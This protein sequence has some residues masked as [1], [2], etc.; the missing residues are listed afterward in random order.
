MKKFIFSILL[1]STLPASAQWWEDAGLPIQLANGVSQIYSDVTTNTMYCTGDLEHNMGTPEQAFHYCTYH[2]GS[3]TRSDPF[4]L[5]VLTAIIYHDTLIVGGAFNS[6]NGEPVPYI[7]Y[8]ANGQWHPYGSIDQSVHRLRIFDGELYATGSFEY[9]D[10]HLC[11]GVAKRVGG[12]WMN[13]GEVPSVSAPVQDIAKYNGELYI[14]GALH[15]Y[16]LGAH[17]IARYDGS[18]WSPVGNGILGGFAVGLRLA[19]YQG[20]L[21]MGGMI[22]IAAGNPG[23]AIMR[24]NGTEWHSVGT[25]LQGPNGGYAYLYTV[26]D[27]SVHNGLLYASGGFNYAGNVPAE[28][29]ATWDGERWC[30]LGGS[31]TS[32]GP[33]YSHGFYGDTLYVGCYNQAD[34]QPVNSLA[35]YIGTGPDTCSVIMGTVGMAEQ[36]PQMPDQLIDLGNGQ[37]RFSGSPHG[38]EVRLYTSTGQLIRTFTVRSSSNGSEPFGLVG[39]APGIYLLNLHG[40]WRG[41]VVIDR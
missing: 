13:V 36:I 31:F 37:Y 16:D 41:R 27:L 40:S 14:T 2:N 15:Y 4:N 11:N 23:H 30:G 18:Q 33:I 35:R 29:I 22:D 10:G 12:T 19:T 5:N 3:W 17:G 6:V 24:W 26:N 8:Q 38:G 9:A 1:F 39:L 28:Y 21:Y 25:G 34:G 7:A 20:E 32:L